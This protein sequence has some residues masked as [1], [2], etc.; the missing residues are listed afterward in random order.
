V[1]TESQRHVKKLYVDYGDRVKAGLL[2]AELD[3]VQL[4]ASLRAAQANYQ[5]AQAAKIQ[6]PPRSSAKWTPK[7]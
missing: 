5:A 4:E 1:E 6:P 2:L 3:K 7:G